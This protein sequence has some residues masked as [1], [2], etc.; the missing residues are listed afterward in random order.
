MTELPNWI[1]KYLDPTKI[2]N[3]SESVAKAESKT[4][5]EI[6]PM[7]VQSSCVTG[8]VPVII[9]CLLVIAYFIL[10]LASLQLN[11]LGESRA[12]AIY[13]INII[14][15][16]TT[17][18]LLSRLS[19]IKRLLTNNE[20]MI[21]Q[22]NMRS[23]LEYFESGITKTRDSTGILLFV[24]IMEHRAVVLADK[25]IS[26]VVPPETWSGVCSTLITGIKSGNMEQAFIDAINE[27][28]K[29]LTPHFP[30]KPDDTNELS[31]HLIIKR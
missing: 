11:Y 21:N 22:V 18:N 20:D 30:I 28:E 10:D 19:L 24:S 8:H 4:S 5:G 27:C 25:A 13:L 7:I 9:F 2:K 6:V 26:D 12:W 16:I 31:N 15:I 1:S 17:T 14:V 29:I 3:I 23:E